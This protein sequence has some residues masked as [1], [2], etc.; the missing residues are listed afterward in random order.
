MMEFHTRI[1]KALISDTKAEIFIRPHAIAAQDPVGPSEVSLRK[2]ILDWIR[3]NL[4]TAAQMTIYPAQVEALV[5]AITAE[6]PVREGWA[7]VPIADE[8]TEEMETAFFRARDIEW[9][10][11]QEDAVKENRGWRSMPYVVYRAMIA[12]APKGDDNAEGK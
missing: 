7:L 9:P 5:R 8:M 4:G 1:R 2:I 12:A 10:K 11:Q 6:H 3:N